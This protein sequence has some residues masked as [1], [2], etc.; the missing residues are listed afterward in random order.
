[1]VFMFAMAVVPISATGL[2]ACGK[3]SS[4]LLTLHVSL[5]ILRAASRCFR[6]L[7][8]RI[9]AYGK[10]SIYQNM[11]KSRRRRFKFEYCSRAMEGSKL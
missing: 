9:P 3:T 8:D 10:I 1:M 2:I 6:V 4:R 11:R 7:S 5:I